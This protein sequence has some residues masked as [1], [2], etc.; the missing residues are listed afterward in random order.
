MT[1]EWSLNE[2][3]LQELPAGVLVLPNDK[4]LSKEWEDEINSVTLTFPMSQLACDNSEFDLWGFI[5]KKFNAGLARIMRMKDIQE[6]C[7][8]N[9]EMIVDSTENTPKIHITVDYA[10]KTTN[11]K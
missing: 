5:R 8:V 4:K 7:I 9:C 3:L 10:K 1:E 2:V 11:N 6:M